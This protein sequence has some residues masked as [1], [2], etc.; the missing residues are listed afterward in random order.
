MLTTHTPRA[1]HPPRD[2]IGD[3]SISKLPHY[4]HLGIV[5]HNSFVDTSEDSTSWRDVLTWGQKSRHASD[6][7]IRWSSPNHVRAAQLILPILDS[8]Y[9]EVLYAGE[10]SIH[11]NSTSAEF[12]ACYFTHFLPLCPTS[13]SHILN[14]T[15]SPFLQGLARLF[16]A[17]ENIIDCRDETKEL[18]SQLRHLAQQ[19]K[20]QAE[21]NKVLSH[22][23]CPR[24][25]QSNDQ[26]PSTQSS[27]LTHQ[28][29][30]QRLYCLNQLLESQHYRLTHWRTGGSI[31]NQPT[32]CTEIGLA[33]AKRI[34][35]EPKTTTSFITTSRQTISTTS[36]RGEKHNE[37]I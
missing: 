4:N 18:H 21:I 19:P 15:H 7:D 26:L 22:Y 27:A 32:R 10:I 23:N 24:L 31:N 35:H 8:H 33:A 25:T 17:L 11:F 12:Y 34:T 14:Q 13:Y 20:F 5:R 28:L 2:F 16:S 3:G 9:S 30:K 36:A 29:T 1:P 37:R 6:Y